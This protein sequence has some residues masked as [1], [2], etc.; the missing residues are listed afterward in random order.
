MTSMLKTANKNNYKVIKSKNYRRITISIK[1]SQNIVV[2]A[3]RGV[4]DK[5][6]NDF[7]EKNKKWITQNLEK[8]ENDETTKKHTYLDGDVFLLYGEP[9][10]L[11]FIIV[12]DNKFCIIDEILNNIK[13]DFEDK[14]I[15]ITLHASLSFE[16]RASIVAEFFREE[17]KKI[18]AKKFKENIF[19]QQT[20]YLIKN[21]KVRKS[22]S[23]WGSCS[24]VNNINFSYRLAMLPHICIDYVILHEVVHL[25]EK[26]HG[27]KFYKKLES[28]CPDYKSREDYIKHLS[29]SN[30]MHLA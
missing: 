23:R 3:P 28:I 17:S 27:K 11:K 22:N 16:S 5:K 25:T 18:V 10:S 26:N 14:L 15:I 9:F 24:G 2:S 13:V 4:S 7:V 20:R 29:K 12:E 19:L 21:I 6:I 8:L 1:R 30:N